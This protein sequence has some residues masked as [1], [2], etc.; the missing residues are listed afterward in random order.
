LT[1]VISELERQYPTAFR[2]ILI[3]SSLTW[4]RATSPQTVRIRRIVV[5]S[6]RRAGDLYARTRASSDCSHLP[7]MSWVLA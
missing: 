6:C 4:Q 5:L 1:Y 2:K 7:V 3:V